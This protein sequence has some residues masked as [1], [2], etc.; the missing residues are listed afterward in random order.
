MVARADGSGVV[1]VA[2]S[3][4]QSDWSPD[5]SSLTV[6][7][8]VDGGP[9][10]S[11]AQAD[12]TG[13]RTLHLGGV[14]PHHGW[15]AWRPTDGAELVFI[16]HPVAAS[17][18]IGL[19]GIAPDGTGLR[20]I[21]EV[22]TTESDTQISFQAPVLS[23]DGSLIAYS[24]WEE[25]DEGVLDGY[26]HVRDLVT[27]VDRRVRARP[28]LE[29]EIRPQFSPDGNLLLLEAQNMAVN[30]AQLV[31]APV[32]GSSPG[33]AIGQTFTWGAPL[34]FA[35]SPDGRQVILTLADG[36]SIIDVASGQTVV[37]LASIPSFPTWQRLAP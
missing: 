12:G 7:H 22:S 14:Q 3:T 6:N 34:G 23:P 27:G 35:F 20:T 37:K 13:I 18:D 9:S 26:L 33:V 30:E 21:G 15:A 36:T 11:I 17:P 8:D 32:D 4:D 16:G 28:W 1:D 2:S 31:V 29:A 24:N 5:D 19:Y 10:V 25:S